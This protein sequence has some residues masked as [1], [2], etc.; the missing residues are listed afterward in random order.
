MKPTKQY[1]D[2]TR[3]GKIKLNIWTHQDTIVLGG[4]VLVIIA[5]TIAAII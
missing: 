5:I 3:W 4:V 1:D 2:I